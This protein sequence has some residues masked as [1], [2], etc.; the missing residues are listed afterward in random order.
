MN[1]KLRQLG[2]ILEKEIDLCA[3]SISLALKEKEAM[4]ACLPDELLACQ[5]KRKEIN[6]EMSNL[7]AVRQGIMADIA[8]GGK[9]G[10]L[11]DVY[12]LAKG[13]LKKSLMR[14]GAALNKVAREL[15][16]I[17]RRN[18]NIAAASLH[19]IDSSIKI[20]KTP[21]RDAPT[22]L[23]S[24]AIGTGPSCVTSISREV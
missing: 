9:G 13:E 8:V 20:L 15:S 16:L 11:S 23:S 18:E 1:H 17:L 2:D 10:T 5:K 4:I 22:Y 19:F 21:A 6:L 24:G 7:E 14:R 12:E 3:D